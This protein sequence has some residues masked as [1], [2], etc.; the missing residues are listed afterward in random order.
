MIEK[1]YGTLRGFEQRIY[2]LSKDNVK[3]LSDNQ[4]LRKE[5]DFVK[6]KVEEM[7]E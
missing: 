7:S 5:L 2:D 3:L 4:T 6:K 1:V